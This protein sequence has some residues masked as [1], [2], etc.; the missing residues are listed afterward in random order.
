LVTEIEHGNILKEMIEKKKI[1]CVYMNGSTIDR[2]IKEH[3]KV[4]IGTS[5]FNEGVDLKYFDVLILAAGG[6]SSVQLIQ[7]VGRV[8][9]PKTDG[10]ESIVYDFIDRSKYINKHY[11][12]RRMILEN[13]FEV[14]DYNVLY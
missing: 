2:E 8:L 11:K 7:R 1:D 14:V 10:R 12:K 4:L 13:D 3:M 6:K 9:R 5:I